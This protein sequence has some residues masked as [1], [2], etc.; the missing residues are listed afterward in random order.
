MN[1]RAWFRRWLL[2]R[3]GKEHDDHASRAAHQ[4]DLTILHRGKARQGLER[5]LFGGLHATAGGKR[6]VLRA[7]PVDELGKIARLIHLG[8]QFVL[9]LG[10][11]ADVE[12]LRVVDATLGEEVR[13]ARR[14]TP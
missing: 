8:A 14:R 5:E 1:G 10:R 3:G 9:A 13:G 6:D 12:L 11:Q 4:R 7:Q 2:A